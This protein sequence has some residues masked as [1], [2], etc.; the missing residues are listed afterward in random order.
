LKAS[1]SFLGRQVA[2]GDVFAGLEMRQSGWAQPGI[3]VAAEQERRS[4]LPAQSHE[5]EEHVL[6]AH[7]RGLRDV[8]EQTAVLAADHAGLDPFGSKPG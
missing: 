8:D 6:D 1:T 4:G 3:V 7:P 5:P 2:A